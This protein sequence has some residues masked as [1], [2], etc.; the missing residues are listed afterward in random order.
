LGWLV[1]AA[2]GLLGVCGATNAAEPSRAAVPEADAQRQAEA[3]IRQSH[4]KE[5]A[6]ARLPADRL[7]LARHL[8]EEARQFQEPSPACFVLYCLARDTA[9]Q[10]G[11]P[12]LV[13]QSIDELA[14]RFDLDGPAL[15][16]KTLL[17]AAAT[18]RTPAAAR[19]LAQAC[20]ESMDAAVAAGEFDAGMEYAHAAYA[21][22]RKANDAA[23][24]KNVVDRGQAVVALQKEFAEVASARAT[25]A[26]RPDDPPANL[27][28]GRYAC[29][30]KNDW[31]QGLPLL[32]RGSDAELKAAARQELALPRDAASQVDLAGRWSK[33]A[34]GQAGPI[35]AALLDHAAGWYRKAMT[36][37]SGA[38]REKIVRRLAEI[39]G[40]AS[41]QGD[42]SGGA[43]SRQPAAESASTPL[44][45]IPAPAGQWID[46][47]SL[48]DLEKDVA[49]GRWEKGDRRALCAA[50]GGPFRKSA[51]V[52][53][54][55]LATP[56]VP[57]GDYDLQITF[58]RV[59]KGLIGVVLPVGPRQCLAVLD[60]PGGINGLD[61]IDGRRVEDNA[62]T[63]QG[64]LNNG[65][66]YVLDVSVRIDQREAA[67]TLTLD[68]RP[69]V[70]YRGPAAA[71]AL[72]P[73]WKLRGP[74][75]LG[76]IAEA[77]VR[78][79]GLRLRPVSGQVLSLR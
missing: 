48:V 32:A 57:R 5:F 36:G 77:E 15:K 74:A 24:V 64:P 50:P 34:E 66:E 41:A 16:C 14:R 1:L 42:T 31:P 73:R 11:D 29:L 3:K 30:L 38:E 63:F 44:R 59:T 70:F 39:K 54:S 65:R 35:R 7:A 8:W 27:L 23:L 25:L 51:P 21:A 4:R 12:D 40:F 71:L 2:L 75:S 18:P 19:A 28:C 61:T 79:Q 68:G 6:K 20:L 58:T 33:L 52:P 60:A 10:W 56:V 69:W 43:G 46:L 76:L 9:A 45:A 49:A 17:A 78:F 37:L 67:V 22:A 47:V 55:M 72:D 53:L 62:S 13:A 26:R